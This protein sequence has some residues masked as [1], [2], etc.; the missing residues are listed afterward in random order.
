MW[1]PGSEA[2]I[3]QLE[4]EGEA[5]KNDGDGSDA[6]SEDGVETVQ[7]W[8]QVRFVLAFVLIFSPYP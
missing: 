7:E 4:R 5:Q 3:L 2:A 1:V 8:L 6:V